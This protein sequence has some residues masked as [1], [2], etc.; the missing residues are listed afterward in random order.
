MEELEKALINRR[1]EYEGEFESSE[2]QESCQDMAS[3]FLKIMGGSPEDRRI[4]VCFLNYLRFFIDRK[5]ED[6]RYW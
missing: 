5:Y 6:S 4:L 2:G 1:I 3:H